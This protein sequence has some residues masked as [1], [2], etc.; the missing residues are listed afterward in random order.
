MQQDMK[1]YD[2]WSYMLNIG[3]SLDKLGNSLSGG[4]HKITISARTGK[5]A[6]KPGPYRTYW[7]LQ[8]AIVNFAFLPVDGP[9]H[10]FQAYTKEKKDSEYMREGNKIVR[11]VLAC[12]ILPSCILIGVVLRVFKGFRG[13]FKRLSVSK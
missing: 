5:H 8:E 9:D 3:I 6:N 4:S 10:C 2:Q 12:I 7:K 1:K 13:M 11:G